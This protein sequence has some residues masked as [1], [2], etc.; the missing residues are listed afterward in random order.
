MGSSWSTLLLTASCLATLTVAQEGTDAARRLLRPDPD[1]DNDDLDNECDGICRELLGVEKVTPM[2]CRWK[3]VPSEE[4]GW[5]EEQLEH[6]VLM[7]WN[8]EGTVRCNG[9]NEC[10]TFQDQGYTCVKSTD[11]G[12]EEDGLNCT[13]PTVTMS[14]GRN[15]RT[16]E[17]ITIASTNVMRLTKRRAKIKRRI[18]KNVSGG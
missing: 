4:N 15:P 7:D 10:A 18:R 8:P 16:G 3:E 5:T 13:G 9:E 6:C 1:D 12:I 11:I 17:D 2:I 14:T